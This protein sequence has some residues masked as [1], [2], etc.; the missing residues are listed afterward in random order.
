M[1]LLAQANQLA[2]LISQ[3]HPLLRPVVVE[4]QRI[5]TEL[6]AGKTRGM[7]EALSTVANY[8]GLIVDRMDKIDD[9]LNWYEATQMPEQSGAFEDVLQGA[10]AEEKRTPPKR[11]D[12][13][14]NYID[15]LQ[16]E[17]E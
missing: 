13:I 7:T 14:S 2:A 5:I 17:F 1:A 9:Y 16:R 3:A 12:A 6:A 10:K 4:Y 15:Q 8:R 11:N